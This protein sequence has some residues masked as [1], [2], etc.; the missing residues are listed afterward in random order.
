MIN[1]MADKNLPVI[2]YGEILW[3]ILP[4]GRVPG[5]APMNVA[6]HLN[7]QGKTSA[8]ITKI[9]GDESG[10]ELLNVL[11]HHNLST[12]FIQIDQEHE[13]GKVYAHP[14]EYNEVVYDIV[15]PSAWDF[16]EWQNEFEEI[17]KG[18]RYF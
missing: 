17:V 5:G 1:K 15:K 6:Y 14:N 10:T 16:I 18:S 8:L 3:D 12:D 9:G 7:K 2:C 11:S 4:S 13:T